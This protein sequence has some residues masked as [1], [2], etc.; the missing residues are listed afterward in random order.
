MPQMAPMS[1]TVLFALFTT[2]MIIIM[3]MTY[4][5]YPPK[6]MSDSSVSSP[7]STNMPWKW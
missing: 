5:L 6:M 4:Y 2:S 3:V 7:T 1:W